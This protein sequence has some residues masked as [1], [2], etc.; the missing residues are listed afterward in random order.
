[1]RPEKPNGSMIYAQGLRRWKRTYLKYERRMNMGYEAQCKGKFVQR[2]NSLERVIPGINFSTDYMT[3]QQIK[4]L[5]GLVH[6]YY[7]PKGE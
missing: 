4:E 5:S 6:T 3:P 1:M 2:L 7:I